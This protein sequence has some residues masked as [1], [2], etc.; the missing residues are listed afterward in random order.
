MTMNLTPARRDGAD[1]SHGRMPSLEAGLKW[2]NY[3]LIEN[4]ETGED[5]RVIR[6]VHRGSD[7]LSCAY[8]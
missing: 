2:L 4:L 8:G 5:L 3:Y 7:S 1:R 6:W